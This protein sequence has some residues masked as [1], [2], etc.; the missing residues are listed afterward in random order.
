[1]P[2]VICPCTADTYIHSTSKTNNYGSS[3]IRAGEGASN[4]NVLRTLF[5]FD[6]S[7]IPVGSKVLW[8]EI[9]LYNYN[10]STTSAHMLS[11]YQLLADWNETEATWINRKTG[12]PW[13]DPGAKGT[14]TINTWCGGL[15]FG[16]S[17]AGH[18]I[19]M[20]L[21]TRYIQDW[22]DGTLPNYGYLMKSGLEINDLQIF[23][24]RE[25]AGYEPYLVVGYGPPDAAIQT[26][27]LGDTY[28][29]T[30][31][32][33]SRAGTANLK[34]GESNAS[35]NL[36]SRSIILP[37]YATIPSNAII[38]AAYLRLYIS[39]QY[40]GI[41][42]VIEAHR[43]LVSA[44]VNAIWAEYR[45][46]SAWSTPGGA[47]GVDFSSVVAGSYQPPGHG[48]SQIGET[49]FIGLDATEVQQMISTGNGLILVT[50]AEANDEFDFNSSDAT[51][52]LPEFGIAYHLP[53]GPNFRVIFVG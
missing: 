40:A 11:V 9:K 48:D 10:S 23:Y 25:T 2:Q 51:A 6:L 12:V 30:G 29:Q 33:L 43:L 16:T 8:A 44:G 42:P 15:T 49:I 5:K 22:V 47:P 26:P 20:H 35:T 53:N 36:V 3:D 50:S 13:A 37:D 4:T 28:I 19:Q 41:D 52:N 7:G 18:W 34:A 17:E 24:S 32:A 38:D 45:P 39:A 27:L 1:M 21:M 46:G 14:E 31:V